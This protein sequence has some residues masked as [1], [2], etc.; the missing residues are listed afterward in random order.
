[1]K[2]IHVCQLRETCTLGSQ[3]L[4]KTIDVTI[5]SSRCEDSKNEGL[6]LHI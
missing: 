2:E 1:M 3:Q 5:S 4:K 6:T